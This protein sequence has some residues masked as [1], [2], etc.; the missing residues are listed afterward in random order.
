[1][2]TLDDDAMVAA[3][4]EEF[5][6]LLGVEAPPQ[7]ASVRRWPESMPQYPVGHLER[8]ATI[9]ARAA[10]IRGLFLAG[11]YLDGVGIPDCVR[12]GE[13]AA[14]A[15]FAEVSGPVT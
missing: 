14:E 13:T 3:A 8:V 11:A 12:H 9:R 15:A 4:R 1:M 5:R 10:A 2:L 6:V 7:F